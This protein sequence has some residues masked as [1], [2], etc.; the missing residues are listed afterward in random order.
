MNSNKETSM[1]S[2]FKLLL[3]ACALF[4]SACSAGKFTSKTGSSAAAP[5]ALDGNSSVDNADSSNSSDE[6]VAGGPLANCDKSAIGIT[7]VKL[8]SDG[9]STLLG[10]Q[11][12][13]YELAV[14][15]CKDGSVQSLKDVPVLFDLDASLTTGFQPVAYAVVDARGQVISN[16]KL[17]V[18]TGTDLFGN[19][20]NYAHWITQNF[21]YS[22]QLEKLILEIKLE[23]IQVL[24][25]NAADN[26]IKSFLR[27]GTAQAVTQPLNI[28][29]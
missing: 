17:E 25:R 29:N 24:P 23:N 13:R 19:A 16:S 4:A 7:Q 20:G 1:R 18:V 8:L 21:S 27:I 2:P 26:Q 12:L 9:I 3:I 14:L 5:D 15:N 6:A 22:S 10:T 11:T 28:I